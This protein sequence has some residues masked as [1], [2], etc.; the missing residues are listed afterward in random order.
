MSS[1]DEVPK[2]H[3]AAVGTISVKTV[4]I[5]FFEGITDKKEQARH[6]LEVNL[7]KNMTRNDATPVGPVMTLPG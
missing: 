1:V 2:K 4:P 6:H 3:T 7:S 5:D